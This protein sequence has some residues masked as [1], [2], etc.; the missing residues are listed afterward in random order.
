VKAKAV[1][2]EIFGFE[3]FRL[4]QEQVIKEILDGKSQLVLMPTG[5]GKSLCYQ[6]PALMLDGTAIV[7]SPLIS[8]MEDQVTN[9]NHFGVK[10]AYYNSTLDAT[11][12]KKTLAQLYN[13]ELKLLYVSPERL[14]QDYFL[15]RL[16]DNVN[17]SLIA[18]DEAHCVSQWGHDFRKEYARLGKLKEHFPAAPIC[19]LTATADEETRQDIVKRLTLPNNIHIASFYRENLRYHVINKYKPMQQIQRFMLQ[20]EGEAGIIYCGTRKKVD[21]VYEQLLKAG[22]KVL[23]YHAG[24]SDE[25]RS[26]AYH[27]F[28]HDNINIIVATIAFGMGVDKPNIR[29]VIHYDIPKSIESYYQE[30]GRAGRDGLTADLLLLYQYSDTIMQQAF[31]NELTNEKQRQIEMGK[32]KSM[33]QFAESSTCRQQVLLN[34]FNET[35]NSPCEQCDN[36]LSPQEKI[37]KTVTAQKILSCIY[38]VGQNYGLHH[39]VDVLKGSKKQKVTS[40]GHDKISTFG[41]LNHC[42]LDEIIHTIQQLIHAGYIH[43][44]IGEFNI[45]KLTEKARPLL[46]GEQ[47]FSATL[48]KRHIHR[49]KRA[50]RLVEVE[51]QSINQPL[52][53]TLKTLR[54]RLAKEQN[55]PPFMVFSDKSLIDMAAKS[56]AT[57]DEMLDIHGVGQY[58]LTTFGDVFLNAI[59]EFDPEIA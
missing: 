34:Y 8:L 51:K 30:T 18:I 48:P 59:K 37:D 22:C 26:K 4:L 15:E 50:G 1:L 33:V 57:L 12:A 39:L 43:Q 11:R 35:D 16:E 14:L 45:L 41:L 17:I 13:N 2:K 54:L 36:C 53:D 5:G 20:H 19:A 7:V 21:K 29:Y 28:K 55:I 49:T 31:I 3:E 44:A 9:L 58:K 40:A 46:K 52:F 10:A 32:L 23:P 47:T 27:E 25:A 38:R 24:L 6:I 42:S 56:P